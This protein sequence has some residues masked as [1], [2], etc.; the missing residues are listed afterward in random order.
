MEHRTDETVPEQVDFGVGRIASLL[1][2]TMP[3][4]Y[5]ICNVLHQR[6]R[7]K[8]ILLRTVTRPASGLSDSLPHYLSEYAPESWNPDP[9]R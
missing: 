2:K 8:I 5:A 7:N 1:I 3:P 6:Y 4:N 9:G